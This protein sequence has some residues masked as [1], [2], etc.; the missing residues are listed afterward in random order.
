MKIIEKIKAVFSDSETKTANIIKLP[1]ISDKKVNQDDA[2]DEMKIVREKELVARNKEHKRRKTE[3]C[4]QFYFVF[5]LI[6][7]VATVM[8]TIY[9]YKVES[10]ENFTQLNEELSSIQLD[11]ESLARKIVKLEGISEPEYE[12]NKKAS[13]KAV[14]AESVYY[15]KTYKDLRFDFVSDD[16]AANLLECISF[17]EYGTAG[18]SLQMYSAGYNFV[19][20][21]QMNEEKWSEIPKVLNSLSPAQLDFL[22]YRVV[23][24]Y[25]FATDI[26]NGGDILLDLN[27]MGIKPESYQ[28]CTEMQIIKFIVFMVNLFEE[29]DVNYEWE[30][31]DVLS[32]F[33]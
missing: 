18:S 17:V 27:S 4:F 21:S 2:S 11:Y 6:V 20:V 24:A 23:D 8:L 33:R 3:I 10:I 28:N 15:D 32:L 7:L 29:N 26:I 25:H 19:L 12:V 30:E 16:E 22:S 9:S 31:Y 14:D 5:M 1:G 13:K